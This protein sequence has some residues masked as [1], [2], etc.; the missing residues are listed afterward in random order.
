MKTPEGEARRKRRSQI[1]ER[2]FADAKEHRN[3]RK[4][5]GRG[6][7]RARAEVGLVVLAQTALMIQRLRQ[8]RANASENSS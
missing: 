8:A 2:A 6:L 4:L 3:L 5:H 1:I 7:K